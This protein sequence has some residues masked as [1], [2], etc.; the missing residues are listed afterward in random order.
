MPE[1][2]QLVAT[3]T[4]H[5]IGSEP[6]GS[7]LAFSAYIDF[8]L[9]KDTNPNVSAGVMCQGRTAHEAIRKVLRSK[10]WLAFIAT[11]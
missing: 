10:R 4:V 11:K 2:N 8:V 7:K 6:E 1:Q 5:R 3:M 9:P